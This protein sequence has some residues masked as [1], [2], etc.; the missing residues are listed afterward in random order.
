LRRRGEHIE[1]GAARLGISEQTGAAVEGDGQARVTA[2]HCG[3]VVGV[4]TTVW[5]A[6]LGSDWVRRG[7]N[8]MN[9]SEDDLEAILAYILAMEEDRVSHIA[10]G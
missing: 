8:G 10:P 9:L 2:F 3:Y 6:G 1:D 7:T 4:A 5:R